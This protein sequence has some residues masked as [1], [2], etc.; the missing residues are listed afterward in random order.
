MPLLRGVGRF[1]DR[2]EAVSRGPR[3]S[4]TRR[5]VCPGRA[6]PADHDRPWSR[7][8]RGPRGKNSSGRRGG[9]ADQGSQEVPV[10]APQRHHGGQRGEDRW[11][12]CWGT[13]SRFVPRGFDNG[14]S[15]QNRRL[16]TG[17]TEAPMTTA[18]TSTHPAWRERRLRAG[19]ERSWWGSPGLLSCRF[20]SELAE[21]RSE[22]LIRLERLAFGNVLGDVRG[23]RQGKQ[24][25]KRYGR[26]PSAQGLLFRKRRHTGP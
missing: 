8:C 17:C 14:G 20:S 16:I 25:E 1:R 11:R 10:R 9:S 5:R 6:W 24:D 15:R 19:P 22:R 7:V 3:R 2:A 26:R 13:H 18:S 12:A 21:D 23:A 4:P